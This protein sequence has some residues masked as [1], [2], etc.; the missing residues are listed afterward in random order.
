MASCSKDELPDQETDDDSRSDAPQSTTMKS[1]RS[2][3][4]YDRHCQSDSQLKRYHESSCSDDE[5]A[6]RAVIEQHRM[7]STGTESRLALN[8]TDEDSFDYV[9][10]VFVEAL[11]LLQDWLSEDRYFAK[12][13]Q[14][15][16]WDKRENLAELLR[17]F[18]D[19]IIEQSPGMVP[20]MILSEVLKH[21]GPCHHARILFND[22]LPSDIETMAIH[23]IKTGFELIASRLDDH[24][25]EARA[26]S[27]KDA[28]KCLF[29]I[30]LSVITDYGYC[31]D[32]LST[33]LDSDHETVIRIT[34]PK[35]LTHYRLQRRGAETQDTCQKLFTA[36]VMCGN[37]ELVRMLLQLPQLR[38]YVDVNCVV[39][40]STGDTALHLACRMG[41]TLINQSF[42][43]DLYLIALR[44]TTSPEV[45]DDQKHNGA[46]SLACLSNYYR[47][48]AALAIA[49]RDCA[50]R[51]KIW[52]LLAM[53]SEILK[54]QL[55]V[56]FEEYVEVT[57]LLIQHGADLYSRNKNGET[58]LHVAASLQLHGDVLLEVYALC[59]ECELVKDLH[60]KRNCA[61][62]AV[63]IKKQLQLGS[64]AFEISRKLMFSSITCKL[65]SPCTIRL[66]TVVRSYFENVTRVIHTLL[67]AGMDVNETTDLGLFNETAL[68]IAANEAS[69]CIAI[70][71]EMY[72]FAATKV[73][74]HQDLKEMATAFGEFLHANVFTVVRELL[75]CNADWH[76]GRSTASDLLNVALHSNQT[77]LLVKLVCQGAKSGSWPEYLISVF[78][79]PTQNVT[80]K[81]LETLSSIGVTVDSRND[82]GQTALHIAAERD[83]DDVVRELISLGADTEA[84]DNAGRTPVQSAVESGSRN[85]LVAFGSRLPAELINMSN[86]RGQTALHIAASEDRVD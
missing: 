11:Q 10:Y 19:E 78:R 22:M 44:L 18:G 46:L 25:L 43:D 14:I 37:S 24:V 59:P 53:S 71:S 79:A 62:M 49:D 7:S 16:C 26:A 23:L 52:R 39:D 60:W 29:N 56:H 6:I 45:V 8:C 80:K 57:Q 35:A 85:A 5:A 20:S 69:K 70:S 68:L 27:G 9:N 83:L 84:V 33:A 42:D 51:L 66:Y 17:S 47:F 77:D 28:L 31:V 48:V 1:K 2:R 67:R 3:E 41:S 4:V 36:A 50:R 38:G 72:T 73:A 13:L 61:V 32:I 63:F 76:I 21:H 64:L 55:N 15:G 65:V 86:A 74:D 54:L 82:V 81:S 40:A 58:A 30:L 75:L 34:L 12:I